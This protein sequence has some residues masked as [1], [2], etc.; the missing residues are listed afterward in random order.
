M[1][2]VIPLSK[3]M[4]NLILDITSSNSNNDSISVI[5]WQCEANIKIENYELILE[6]A[7]FENKARGFIKLAK[8]YNSSIALTPE[9]SFSWTL[10][11]DII[12][13]S[14][15]R[16]QEA[17][18][19]CL[20]MQYIS[21]NNFKKWCCKHNSI[22][23][24]DQFQ[25]NAFV[26][27]SPYTIIFDGFQKHNQFVNILA[28]L[29]VAAKGKL[30]ILLQSK[31]AHMGDSLHKFESGRLSLGKNIFLFE[32]NNSSAIKFC[33]LICADGFQK[34]YY[35]EIEKC[36]GN[37]CILLFHPQLNTQPYHDGL[38]TQ[39]DSN[40][41]SN[42]QFLRL[43]WSQFST[44]DSKSLD[45]LGTDYIYKEKDNI[46]DCWQKKAF[47]E[48]YMINRSNGLNL[49]MT[50]NRKC[51]WTFPSQEH[52]AVY[53]IKK[54]ISYFS[55]STVTHDRHQ[56]I[57]E[58]TYRYE[59]NWDIF[60]SCPL[61]LF[62]NLLANFRSNLIKKLRVELNCANCGTS[63]MCP[64]ILWDRFISLCRGNTEHKTF[65]KDPH[66]T[67][68]INCSL[69]NLSNIKI[70]RNIEAEFTGINKMAKYL[71][72]IVSHS[73][74]SKDKNIKTLQYIVP[75]GVCFYIDKNF[76][77]NPKSMINIKGN[78]P[79]GSLY[80][81][82]AVYTKDTLTPDLEYK[83]THYKK[84][85]EANLGV[86]LFYP[87][88]DNKVKLFPD[89]QWAYSS[90]IGPKR[91]NSTNFSEIGIGGGSYD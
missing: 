87:H 86:L 69:T 84:E 18:L 45:T 90:E 40:L 34:E 20:G 32:G 88:G 57:A 1:V 39:I 38:I 33:S 65:F 61:K 8:E 70:Q 47:R 37:N 14:S 67:D 5:H 22:M 9:Y 36:R 55:P 85:T 64:L 60:K 16:P 41:N 4:P 53:F 25:K 62:E 56:F 81:G 71:E 52:I 51:Q 49:L 24:T 50:D 75:N 78:P 48:C 21:L 12:T 17:K 26:D 15:L 42:W 35:D 91:I 59:R 29:F 63:D 6:N 46:Q 76:P 13:D 3:I 58:K 2:Q 7:E 68:H 10:L 77:Q 27:D 31:L 28:Y 72:N 23:T 43:N 79:C 54:P 73:Q 89:P 83:L 82:L 44:I 66:E 11:D 74:N 30:M 80:E 19:W